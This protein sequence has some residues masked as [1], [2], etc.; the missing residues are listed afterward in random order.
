MR[1]ILSILIFVCVSFV[2]AG[3][4]NVKANVS[5]KMNDLK[6]VAPP[7]TVK[8][9]LKLEKLPKIAGSYSSFRYYIRCRL[10]RNNAVIKEQGKI[11]DDSNLKD[12]DKTIKFA[13]VDIGLED[14]E[15]INSVSCALEIID[16]RSKRVNRQI[17]SKLPPLE[18]GSV[19]HC[20][21]RF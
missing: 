15:R 1:R 12:I 9:P 16:I 19:L 11:I 13:F 14:M 6:N 5:S 7:I 8:V 20:E 10:L 18:H 4:P 21:K 3:S 2:F 17:F